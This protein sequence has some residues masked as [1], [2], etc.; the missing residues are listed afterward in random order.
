MTVSHAGPGYEK[1]QSDALGTFDFS[2]FRKNL[3]G[4][5][6]MRSGAHI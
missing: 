1:S 3:T 5:Y 2:G 6:H 4:H